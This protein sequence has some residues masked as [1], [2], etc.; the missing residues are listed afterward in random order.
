M[1]FLTKKNEN[2]LRRAPCLTPGFYFSEGWS[3]GPLWG[4]EDHTKTFWDFGIAD[5][6]TNQSVVG[7]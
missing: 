5:A 7:W 2:G 6:K 3:H 4:G 1:G